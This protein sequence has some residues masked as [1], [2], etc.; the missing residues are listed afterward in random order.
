L[1][2]EFRNYNGIRDFEVTGTTSKIKVDVFAVYEVWEEDLS[3]T[4]K[5]SITNEI[6]DFIE[7]EFPSATITGRVISDDQWEDLMYEFKN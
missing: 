7:D 4:K 1:Y 6:I 3:S 5:K 2:Y